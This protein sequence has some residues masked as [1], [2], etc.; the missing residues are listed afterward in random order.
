MLIDVSMTIEEGIV[1]RLGSPS[2]QITT[3]RFYN[4][5]DGEYDTIMLSLP[6]HTATHVDLVFS[7]KRM[8]PDRMIGNGKLLDVSH[9]PGKVIHLADVK[10]QVGIEP[11]DFVFFRTDWSRFVGTEEYRDHPELA[12][13]VLEWLIDREVNAVGIDAQGLGRGRGHGEYDR[14]LARHDI[15]VIENLTNLAA[16]PR[17]HFRTYCFPLKLGDSD[18]LPARVLVEI[19]EG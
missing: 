19:D 9:L 16:I 13:E 6:A 14:L 12:P 17:N 10:H 2:A 18:A 15:F 8:E 3:Q 11:G 1:F 5:S 7:D 4:E